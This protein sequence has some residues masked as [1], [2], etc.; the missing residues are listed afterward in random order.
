LPV[1]ERAP[2]DVAFATLAAQEK[3]RRCPKCSAM[4]ELKVCPIFP[5]PFPL[6]PH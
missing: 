2:E 5:S 4:V 6:Y 1:T 3:W